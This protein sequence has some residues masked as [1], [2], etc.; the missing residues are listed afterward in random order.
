[1]LLL[2]QALIWISHVAITAADLEVTGPLVPILGVVGDSVVLD[3]LLV[4]KKPLENME[5]RWINT[6]Y[7]YSSPVHT[8]RAGE[9]DLTLQPLVYRGRTELFLDK[10]AQGN[11]SLWLKD[12]R[13]SD[14]GQ[15]KCFVTS[16]I[17]H[18]EF[19]LTLDV[20][21][22][23]RQPTIE[24]EGQ[25]GDGIRLGCRS[26]GWYPE[27]PVLWSDGDG[28]NVA[29]QQQTTYQPDTQELL[30]VSSFIEIPKQSTNKYTCVISNK[31]LEEKQ[32]AHIQIAD[33]FFPYVSQWLIAFWILFALVIAAVALAVWYLR[34]L[35]NEIQGL[36]KSEDNL[37]RQRLLDVTECEKLQQKLEQWRPL[38]QSEWNR[39][40]SY[41]APAS[42]TLDPNTAHPRLI[43]SE[44][45]T[46][47]RLGYKRQLL[48]DSPERFD[49]WQCILG[50]E[51]FTS[52]SHYWEVEVGEKIMWI[53]GV[54]RE[55]VRRKGW[56]NAVEETG[57]W[58]VALRLQKGYF[59]S[60][61]PSWTDLSLHVNPRKIGVFL[62]YEGGQVSFYNAV[63]MSHLH[64]FTHTFTDRIFP[65]F[66]PGRNIDGNNS[67]PLTICGIK[68]H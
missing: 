2:L 17:K 33:S 18:N 13:V 53:L 7:G 23:G 19:K 34:K 27:P 40:Q 25:T 3:C 12:V 4:M 48:P 35:Q 49:L 55:S 54:V 56:I 50:S 66:N 37:E 15:Y 42:L 26:K 21:G 14:R 68:G 61:S 32:E 6:A 46:S 60:T 43:L 36:R 8:Y 62:D 29:A 11:L 47:V 67:G 39:I 16:A 31:I 20:T 10:V 51:G 58:I 64:T 38:V 22:T 44:D 41:A 5:V 63:T 1:M 28:E 9:D 24:M 59:A 65:F 52:G 57:F 30:T 45:R